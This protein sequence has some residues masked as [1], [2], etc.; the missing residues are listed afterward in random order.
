MFFALAFWLG[1]VADATERAAAPYP[2]YSVTY[3]RRTFASCDDARR[4]AREVMGTSGEIATLHYAVDARLLVSPNG[5]T[6]TIVYVKLSNLTMVLPDWSWPG[7]EG[8]SSLATFEAAVANHEYGHLQIAADFLAEG[9]ATGDTYVAASNR[10][11]TL[12]AMRQYVADL[13]GDLYNRQLRYDDVTQH[14]IE[15]SSASRAGLRIADGPD[16]VFG[17]GS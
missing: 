5:K 9:N 4:Y 13:K 14:G 17:C 12:A 3:A 10:S 8:S 2:P 15:Q 16:I 1:T 7:S 11:G 6:A